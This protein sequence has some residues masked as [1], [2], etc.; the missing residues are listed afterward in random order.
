LKHHPVLERDT[1]NWSVYDEA[2]S[3]GNRDI[4]YILYLKRRD[5]IIKWLKTDGIATIIAISNHIGDLILEIDWQV[6]SWIPF[7]STLCPK[8]TV[9]IFKRDQNVKI[10]FTLIG[11]ESL[12][13]IRGKMSLMLHNSKVVLA[14]HDRKIFQILYPLNSTDLTQQEISEEISIALNSKIVPLTCI[15]H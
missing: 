11:F 9:K 2:I 12:S 14:D 10:D 3:I 1:D 13:W 15:Y 5:E 6:T 8:D 7:L 4:M